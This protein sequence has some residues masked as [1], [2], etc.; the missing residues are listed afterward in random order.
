MAVQ[1]AQAAPV[2]AELKKL[3]GLPDNLIALDLRMRCNEIVTV[4]CTYHPDCKSGEAVT[5]RFAIS[6]IL[7][8][9]E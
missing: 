3:L 1:L 2:L 9:K 4:T 8:I 7:D 5:K 6:E